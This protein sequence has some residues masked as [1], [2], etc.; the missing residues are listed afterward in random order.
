MVSMND[1]DGRRTFM[2][3]TLYAAALLPVSLAPTLLGMA[4]SV[5]FIGA[6]A[7]SVWFLMAS[8]AATRSTTPAN[9]RRLFR[10]SLAYLP[11]L[12]ILMGAD[13][14]V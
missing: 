6:T 5:Y 12:L 3:S 4:G 14:V 2:Y 10:V 13:R 1:P 8:V 7:L 11:V 9:A